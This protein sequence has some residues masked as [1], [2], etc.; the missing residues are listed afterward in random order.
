MKSN[1]DKS[2][3]TQIL[4]WAYD[5]S[6]EGGFTEQELFDFFNIKSNS[7]E[8]YLYLKVFKGGNPHQG[9]SSIIVHF[10]NKNDVSYWCLSASG[11][12]AAVDY[13]ELK[14][15]QEGG[16]RATRIAIVSIV[17]GVIVGIAQIWVAV[18]DK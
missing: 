4:L 1:F 10:R 5:K 12:A 15:A 13:K 9:E 7:D 16:K 2:W 14:E 18:C 17:I 6:H 11:M 8:Y 3:Y